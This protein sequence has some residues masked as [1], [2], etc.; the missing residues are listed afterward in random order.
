MSD[1]KK[2]CDDMGMGPGSEAGVQMPYAPQMPYAA[3][4][5]YM[6]PVPMMCCPVLMNMQCP[7]LYGQGMWGAGQP[8]GMNYMAPPYMSNPYMNYPSM[9]MQY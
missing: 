2:A 3:Q 5:P 1:E 9:G 7:M 6:S 8:A 4:M